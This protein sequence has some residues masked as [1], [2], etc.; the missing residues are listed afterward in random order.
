LSYLLGHFR[1][2]TSWPLSILALGY[3][4]PRVIRPISQWHLGVMRLA[5]LEKALAKL[6]VE[7]PDFSRT[8]TTLLKDPAAEIDL[9]NEMA[10]SRAKRRAAA[11]IAELTGTNN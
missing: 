8:L 10:G 11:Q 2:D 9:A 4:V 3:L 5:I 1:T 6:S 7:T